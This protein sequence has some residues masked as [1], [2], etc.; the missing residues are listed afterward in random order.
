VKLESVDKRISS[1]IVWSYLGFV[2]LLSSAANP[3]GKGFLH[4]IVPA[5]LVLTSL[6][7]FLLLKKLGWQIAGVFAALFAGILIELS[8]FAGESPRRLLPLLLG[9]LVIQAVVLSFLAPDGQS[10]GI[11]LIVTAT[12][13]FVIAIGLYLSSL[14]AGYRFP[15][16]GLFLF[17]SP[18]VAMAT[19]ISGVAFGWKK[20]SQI[21][22]V[23]LIAQPGI[24][25]FDMGTSLRET[26]MH[27]FAVVF[28]LIALGFII[29]WADDLNK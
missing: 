17:W 9:A 23:C 28:V 18:L 27:A 21:L 2:G 10:R 16:T 12:V 13:G 8:R 14:E 3:Y 20:S 1:V 22:F 25:L 7:W 24:G 19:W 4:R 6:Q 29:A 26:W 5:L 15:R 11:F